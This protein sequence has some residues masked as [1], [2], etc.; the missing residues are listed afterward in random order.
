MGLMEKEKKLED[1]QSSSHNNIENETS[2]TE[3][4]FIFI[5]GGFI[6]FGLGYFFHYIY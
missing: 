5:I 1:G 3:E 6:G 2:H 4:L